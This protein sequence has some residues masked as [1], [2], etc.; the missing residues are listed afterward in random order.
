MIFITHLHFQNI[1]G[2]LINMHSTC[3]K[4]GF[5]VFALANAVFSKLGAPSPTQMWCLK[6]KLRACIKRPCNFYFYWASSIS[7]SANTL[8]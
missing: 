5:D 3:K 2:C 8:G 6:K 4:S 1:D 7:Q